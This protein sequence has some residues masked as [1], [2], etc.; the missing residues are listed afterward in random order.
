MKRAPIRAIL[1]LF[2]ITRLLLILV[3]YFGYILLTADKY[4]SILITRERFSLSGITGMQHDMSPL[5]ST[6][7]RLPLILPSFLFFHCSLVYLP[8]LWAIGVISSLLCYS[9]MS[10]CWERYLCSTNSPLIKLVKNWHA[11]RFSTSV[12]FQLPFSFSQPI[13]SRYSCSWWQVRF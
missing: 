3:T 13:T 7:I 9:V 12:Y 5:H 8:H 4:S 1:W 6:A 2:L 11:A 10:L